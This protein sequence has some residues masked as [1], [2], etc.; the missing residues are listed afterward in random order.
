MVLYPAGGG[1][2]KLR[3]LAD[4]TPL[5]V[6]SGVAYFVSQ[7]LIGTYLHQLGPIDVW[8]LQTTFSSETFKAIVSGWVSAG[9]IGI[10]YGH[11]YFDYFHP[12]WYGAF[13]S[14]LMARAFNANGIGE[15]F[16]L[17]LIAPFIAGICDLSENNLHLYFLSNLDNATPMMV[18]LSGTLTNTKWLLAFS[19]VGAVAVLTTTWMVKKVRA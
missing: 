17:F 14:L 15:R 6:L 3:K 2:N 9:K 12:L 4:H 18:A 5:I 7:Y 13:L 1:L 16:N 11:Y 10:Y 8:R 19:C